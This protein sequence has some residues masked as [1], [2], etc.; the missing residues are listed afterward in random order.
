MDF[1]GV[2]MYTVNHTK[3]GSVLVYQQQQQKQNF[4]DY[5]YQGVP[6]RSKS[7]IENVID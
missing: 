5:K 2:Y 1:K 4:I 7:I 6:N 3:I